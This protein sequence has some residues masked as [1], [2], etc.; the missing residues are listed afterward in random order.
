MEIWRW[1]A[2]GYRYPIFETIKSTTYKVETPYEHFTT[3]FAYMPSEQY[4][5][6]PHDAENQRQREIKQQE[7]DWKK[8]RDNKEPPISQLIIRFKYIIM[9]YRFI[10]S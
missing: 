5:D 9:I 10:M 6:L 4:Y 7:K 2:S 3:S 8:E 1:Y